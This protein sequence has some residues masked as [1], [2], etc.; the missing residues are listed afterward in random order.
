MWALQQHS[1]Y[2]VNI[3][4]FLCK[5][6]P[7]FTKTVVW[8]H[9]L[10]LFA[11]LQVRRVKGR[12]FKWT[13]T[14][15]TVK[16]VSACHPSFQD[17]THPLNTSNMSQN[18]PAEKSLTQTQYYNSVTA[19][20]VRSVRNLFIFLFILHSNSAFLRVSH[21]TNKSCCSQHSWWKPERLNDGQVIKT[22][23][24][25]EKRSVRRKENAEF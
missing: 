8:I 23:G 20:T 19:T 15:L 14:I 22:A 1:G 9:W 2:T 17:L 4:C 13:Q 16:Q 12:V 11:Y 5:C 3:L 7:Y 6:A 10:V 18:V 25:N 21:S 24:W